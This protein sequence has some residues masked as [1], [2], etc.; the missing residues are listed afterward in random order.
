MH[1]AAIN[2]CYF[3]TV[4][5]GAQHAAG[6]VVPFFEV[7][8]LAYFDCWAKMKVLQMCGWAEWNGSRDR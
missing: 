2:G 4:P 3:C 1:T 8:W 6:Q 7:E 5:E